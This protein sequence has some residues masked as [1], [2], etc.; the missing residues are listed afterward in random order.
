MK[1][2]S[3]PTLFGGDELPARS[4]ETPPA[5]PPDG[6]P[7]SSP[8]SRTEPVVG[9]DEVGHRADSF[10]GDASPAQADDRHVYSVSELTARIRGLVE[11]AFPEVWVEGEISNCR[12][13]TTGHLYFTLKDDG[14][15]VRAV[16]WRSAIRGLKFRPE[17]GLHVIAR[18]AIGVYEPKGEYQLVCDR[19]EPRG[20]GALQLAVEQL[21]KRLQA[22]GLFEAAR[23]RPL[24]AMPAKIG[25]VTSLDGAA[26]RD[27]LKVMD[28]RYPNV[29][30]VIRPARV[31]GEGAASDIA[32]G[33]EAIARVPGVEVVI[34]GR[35]GGSIEDL[36]AFNEEVV[37]RAIAASPIP[38]ISAVGHETD[39]TVADLVADLRAPTPSA[40]AEMVVA[41][42]DEVVARVE[43]LA[44]R[45]RAALAARVE[46]GRIATHRLESRPAFSHLRAR[47]AMRGRDTAELSHRLREAM[48]DRRAIADRRLQG[49]RLRLEARDLRR[50]LAGMG[51]RLAAARVALGS[52]ALRARDRR[53]ARLGELAGR[54]D[55]LSPLAVLGRGYAVCWTGDRSAIV[56][57]ATQVEAGDRVRVTLG[58]GELACTVDDTSEPPPPGAARQTQ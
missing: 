36:W 33:L 57:D 30:V 50:G 43:R 10:D 9:P 7:R 54:L 12:L 4:A 26:L 58:R 45:A 48:A 23:K 16:M 47:I 37:A 27:I 17:D 29:R 52:I 49:L 13:W 19:L 40:A 39:T 31:Q 55:S 5:T 18:G 6:S 21:K 14:A 44:G 25:I 38:V 32:R 53:A 24:P 46:R 35:G 34:V 2:R 56:R 8:D 22:E 20:L 41:R 1:S 11:R 28:R 42:K 15:Q 3:Q 51:A